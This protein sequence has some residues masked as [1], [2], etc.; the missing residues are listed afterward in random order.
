MSDNNGKDK[1]AER[2][3][4][5]RK[6][7]GKVLGEKGEGFFRK[8][9]KDQEAQMESSADYAKGRRAG[10]GGAVIDEYAKGGG[11]DDGKGKK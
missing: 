6:L 2:G 11:T 10:G 9:D 8:K 3:H 7:E 5:L 4:T 1:E